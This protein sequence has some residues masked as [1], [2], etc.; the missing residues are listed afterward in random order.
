MLTLSVG[1][2]ADMLASEPPSLETL[3]ILGCG[4]LLISGR[5][6]SVARHAPRRFVSSPARTSLRLALLARAGVS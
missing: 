3:T 1:V 6:A 5:K 4:E 2:P